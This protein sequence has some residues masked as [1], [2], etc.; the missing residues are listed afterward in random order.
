MKL[1][2]AVAAAAL[3]VSVTGCGGDT[4]AGSGAAGEATATPSGPPAGQTGGATGSATGGGTVLRATVGSEDDPDAYEIVLTDT[5]GEVVEQLPPGT[6]RIE[7]RDLSRIH[8][9]HLLGPGVDEATS[10]PEV[11]NVTFTVTLGE[12]DYR[13][14][15]DPHPTMRGDLAVA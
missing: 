9:F 14:V 13:Y 4:G 6:Y 15:C 7:V 8:N 5:S 11:E 3:A 1:A 10:V 2:R 12:G